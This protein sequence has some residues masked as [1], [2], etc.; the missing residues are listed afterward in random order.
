MRSNLK[1]AR[2]RNQGG[3]KIFDSREGPNGLSCHEA[4]TLFCVGHDCDLSLSEV[5][6]MARFK[7]LTCSELIIMAAK[8]LSAK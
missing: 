3:A 5:D 4:K 6:L 7:R 8:A 2:R 1:A